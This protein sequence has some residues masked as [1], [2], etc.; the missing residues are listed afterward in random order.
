MRNVKKLMGWVLTVVM[1]AT[2]LVVPTVQAGEGE[3]VVGTNLIAN[4]GFETVSQYEETEFVWADGWYPNGTGNFS[5]SEVG[6][7]VEIVEDVKHN[8]QKALKVTTG[9][10]TAEGRW[11]S[12]KVENLTPGKV[13]QASAWVRIDSALVATAADY[14]GAE[15]R[16]CEELLSGSGTRIVSTS[17]S[18]KRLMLTTDGAWMYL[19]CPVILTASDTYDAKS[20]YVVLY[21]GITSESG[22]TVYWDDV[23][24]KE[25]TGINGD[26][27]KT[28]V[29]ADGAVSINWAE[30]W[31][32]VNAYGSGHD[33]TVG[34]TVT[35]SNEEKYL[36]TYA[37]KFSHTGESNKTQRAYTIVPNL[38]PGRTYQVTGYAYA[39]GATKPTSQPS[40]LA[41]DAHTDLSLGSS[42][43][44]TYKQLGS[45]SA[46]NTWNKIEFKFV[47]PDTGYIW[48]ALSSGSISKDQAMFFDGI[49]VYEASVKFYNEDDAELKNVEAGTVKAI[50]KF[51]NQKAGEADATLIVAVYGKQ[52]GV[53]QLKSVDVVSTEAKVA[54]LSL[55]TITGSVTA[56]PGDVIKAMIL[57]SAGALTPI[58][59][60][61]ILN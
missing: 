9:T 50:A 29:I 32:A 42:A 55:G 11:I 47:A 58:S 51:I 53:K 24:F 5:N 15:I 26:F 37:L 56:E 36:N 13:Y 20:A 10:T 25:I 12:Y 43:A 39:K 16:V 23:S 19:S 17:A 54:S 33:G 3:T 6:T 49:E 41:M 2:L 48:L 30:G 40:I 22:K 46:I 14:K 21:T 38:V 4:G 34:S 18:T 57:D 28:E 44:I 8:G 31:S 27:E 60:S 59:D 1:L 52:N 35:L 45:G 61:F 7:E